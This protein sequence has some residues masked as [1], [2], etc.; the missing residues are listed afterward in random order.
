MTT[1]CQQME[2][3]LAGIEGRSSTSKEMASSGHQRHGGM[4]TVLVIG[5]Q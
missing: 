3:C 5:I 2:R 1:T 4:D